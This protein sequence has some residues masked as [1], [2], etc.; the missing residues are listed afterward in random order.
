MK[1]CTLIEQKLTRTFPGSLRTNISLNMPGK[2]RELFMTI[3]LSNHLGVETGKLANGS[4]VKD[5]LLNE[6]TLKRSENYA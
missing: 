6:K 4:S 2:T 5:V 1:L 3:Q